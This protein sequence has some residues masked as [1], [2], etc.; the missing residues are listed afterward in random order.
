MKWF[1]KR[2][3]GR[4]CAGALFEFDELLVMLSAHYRVVEL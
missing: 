3:M 1:K 2:Q 4:A